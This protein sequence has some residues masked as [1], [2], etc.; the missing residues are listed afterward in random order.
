MK[1]NTQLY[2]EPTVQHFMWGDSSEFNSENSKGSVSGGI[3]IRNQV[4]LND[5]NVGFLGSNMWIQSAWCRFPQIYIFYFV[6]I[7]TAS[8]KIKLKKNRTEKFLPVT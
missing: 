5:E 6:C 2:Y 8:G 1:Y 7:K 4:T 3:H